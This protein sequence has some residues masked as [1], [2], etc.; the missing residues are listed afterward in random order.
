VFAYDTFMG[1]TTYA[2]PWRFTG[3]SSY[4]AIRFGDA[5]ESSYAFEIV[6]MSCVCDKWIEISAWRG[7]P[8]RAFG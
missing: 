6:I 8:E 3:S 4:D 2:A 1:S 7:L 5:S